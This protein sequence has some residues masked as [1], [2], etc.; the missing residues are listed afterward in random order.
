M[1]PDRT[2]REPNKFR[3]PASVPPI[4][5]S[6]GRNLK[7]FSQLTRREQ[8]L[9]AVFVQCLPGLHFVLDNPFSTSYAIVQ[10]STDMDRSNQLLGT[11]NCSPKLPL[12]KS[13]REKLRKAMS[14]KDR[15]KIAEEL[16][17]VVGQ[18]ITVQQLNEWI[19]PSGR[20]RF[21]AFLVR[22]FSEVVGNDL[23]QRFIMGRRLQDLVCLGELA[24][25]S[26][27]LIGTYGHGRRRDRK[28]RC[29]CRK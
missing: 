5:N 15:P 19:A 20:R 29:S 28:K 16:S 24:L 1:I 7:Q 23:L 2:I 26:D 17:R 6:Q 12:D 9:H 22:P 8:P 3:T 4:L 25:E 27:G 11:E 18:R 14:G 21:P 13:L 10:Y